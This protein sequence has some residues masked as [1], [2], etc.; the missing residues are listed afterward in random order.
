MSIQAQL[1]QL[2]NLSNEDVAAK[3]RNDVVSLEL[4]WAIVDQCSVFWS[5]DV[6]EACWDLIEADAEVAAEIHAEQSQMCL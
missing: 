2:Q 3:I 6:F 4:C 5:E 1:E